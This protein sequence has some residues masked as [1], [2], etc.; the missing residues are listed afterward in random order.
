M[1]WDQSAMASGWILG[2]ETVSIFEGNGRGKVEQKI[3]S[4][5]SYV[6]SHS[7]TPLD[8]SKGI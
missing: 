6:F 3:V 2:E 5:K 7:F 1:V 8:T 4:K